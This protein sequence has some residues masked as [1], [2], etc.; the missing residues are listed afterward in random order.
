M[1]RITAA[2]KVETLTSLTITEYGASG[3]F[4]ARGD[5][6][7]TVT[8]SM[9]DPRGQTRKDIRAIIATAEDAGEAATLEAISVWL[10]KA[11]TDS[12]ERYGPD[13]GE[14]RKV[15]AAFWLDRGQ[16]E[17]LANLFGDEPVTSDVLAVVDSAR[18]EW[19]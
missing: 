13:K 2:K 17:A 8:L 19:R 3:T 15:S 18:A 12:T 5:G 1:A 9:D 4:E 11:D 7:G 14:F 16:R 10:D 6:T